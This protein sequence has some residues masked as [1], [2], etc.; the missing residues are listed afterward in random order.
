M[1]F[2]LYVVALSLS[3][4]V[5]VFC[6]GKFHSALKPLLILIVYTTLHEV[7]VHLK[8]YPSTFNIYWVYTGVSS[9]L[10]LEFMRRAI[11]NRTMKI[12]MG[13]LAIAFTLMGMIFAF[14]MRFTFPSQFIMAA[15]PFMILGCILVLFTLLKN[16]TEQAISRNP[17]FIAAAAI[18][19]YQCVFFTYFG[20]LNMLMNNDQLTDDIQIIFKISSMIYYSVLGYSFIRSS[21]NSYKLVH[22]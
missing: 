18:L 19:I 13:V 3:S 2:N 4:L 22:L 6:F 14:P 1:I 20:S 16:V 9:G 8:C 5:G 21:K 15:I 7:I 10:Y 12:A 11:R 17:I